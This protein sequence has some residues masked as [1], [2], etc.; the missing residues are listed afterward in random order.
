MTMRMRERSNMTEG[1]IEIIIMMIEIKRGM[2][3]DIYMYI[4]IYIYIYILKQ[5]YTF[6]YKYLCI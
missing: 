3:L 1:K 5:I 2:Y 4:C 6:G